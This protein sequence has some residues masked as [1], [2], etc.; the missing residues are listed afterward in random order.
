MRKSPA[1]YYSQLPMEEQVPKAYAKSLH[2]LSFRARSE[3]EMRDYLTK[4]GFDLL[5]IQNIIELL[6]KEKLINDIE[7][8]LNWVEQRQK[9][10][11]KSKSFIQFELKLKG[12]HK[13]IIKD[14]LK[15]TQDDYETAKAY[16][17]KR[18]KRFYGLPPEDYRRKASSFLQNRGFSWEVVKQVLKNSQG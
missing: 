3:K 2:Y 4:K 17:D 12:I 6:K 13:D 14:A 18:K 9:N 7:F 10:K 1:E 8:A 5:V 16:F 15:D 11:L